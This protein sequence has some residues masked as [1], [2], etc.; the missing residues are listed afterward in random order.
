MQK[1]QKSH[2]K[3]RLLYSFSDGIYVLD[4]KWKN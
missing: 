2:Y 3:S 1:M 4:R